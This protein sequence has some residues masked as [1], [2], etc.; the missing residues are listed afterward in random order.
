M[1]RAQQRGDSGGDGYVGG[2]DGEV[3]KVGVNVSVSVPVA[4][5]HI[6]SLSCSSL[7]FVV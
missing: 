6:P 7:C 1:E 2:D 5:G 3:L 4:I